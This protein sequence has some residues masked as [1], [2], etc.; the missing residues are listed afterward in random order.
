MKV[1]LECSRGRANVTHDD[2]RDVDLDNYK[3][4]LVDA[5]HLVVFMNDIKLFYS[6][7]LICII[8]MRML[9]SHVEVYI[10]TIRD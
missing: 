10:N 8:I 7:F 9:I 3:L 2:L 1:T 4:V 5:L 6:S